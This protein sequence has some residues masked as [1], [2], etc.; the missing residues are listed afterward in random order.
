MNRGR[1]IINNT[2]IYSAG[3]FGSRI[4]AYVMVLVYTHYVNA[5]E[6]GYYDLILTSISLIQPIVLLA[7]DE[8][9]YRWL[10]GSEKKDDY[11][12]AST[13][14]KT[15]GVTTSLAGL[16]VI[17][18]GL[19][20]QIRN[21]FLITLFLLS[22]SVYQMAI[23]AVRGLARSKLYAFCGIIN[24]LLVLTFEIVGLVFLSMGIEALLISKI[25]SNFFVIILIYYKEPLFQRIIS[26]PYNPLIAKELIHY[27]T[28]L[29]PNQVSW[30]IVNFSD[31]YIIRAAM[32]TV[33]NGVYSVSSKFPTIIT[34]ISGIIYFS[35]QE[36]I[37]KE[38]SREDRDSFFSS[39]F[40]SYYRALFSLI[41]VFMPAT[42]IAIKL[43]V[44]ETYTNAWMYTGFLYLSTVF[45]SLSSLLG[46][47]YQVSRE[48][49][50]S[51]LST[52]AAG[53]VNVIINIVLIKN[54][55][56]HA[57]SFS[58]LMAYLVLFIIRVIHTKR[59]FTLDIDWMTFAML[60]S[61]SIVIMSIS[62]IGNVVVNTSL[63]LIAAMVGFIV[64]R[65]IIERVHGNLLRS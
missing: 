48:T 13:C 32:G 7:L 27:S 17:L 30:W 36:V 10:V 33:A 38:Y 62:Y 63:V 55:G 52:L 60:L 58:T 22:N 3:N 29:I 45:S 21:P 51:V 11:A 4:L 59:Y 65:Q 19:R 1:R 2:I 25:M 49:S 46:I 43:L 18:V 5:P 34:S 35:V 41:C 61:E 53:V 44:G 39:V 12:A 56:L 15:I 6:L 24:T 31:R 54:I 28:P 47:G 57:A 20:F 40:R 9:I 26:V 37:I 42:N 14:F 8:G 50:R 64:N 16:L 23:S